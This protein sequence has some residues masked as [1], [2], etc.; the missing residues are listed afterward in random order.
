LLE[1]GGFCALGEIGLD[2]Y[3]S[4][5]HIAEQ[6]ALLRAQLELATEFGLPLILHCRQAARDLLDVLREHLQAGELRGVWHCFEGSEDEAREM[7]GLGFAISV[8]VILTFPGATGL[9]QVVARLQ[10]DRVLIETDAPY[11]SPAPLRGKVNE[12]AF[13]VHTLERL[14]ELWNSTRED[15]EKKLDRET[16]RLFGLDTGP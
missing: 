6:I 5:D 3:H 13:L 7:L 12:P 10:E 2:Y 8:S 1:E 11:L 14:A 9:R 4:R 15:L 16:Y